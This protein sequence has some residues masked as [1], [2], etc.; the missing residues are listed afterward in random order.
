MIINIV[1]DGAGTF[2]GDSYSDYG[3]TEVMK[4]LN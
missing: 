4:S 1:L 2:T 3:V